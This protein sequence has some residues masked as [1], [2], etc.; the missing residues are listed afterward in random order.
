MKYISFL[1]LLTAVTFSGFS[2]SKDAVLGKWVNSSGEANIEIF[3]K[4][5]QYFGKI[6][7]LKNPKDDKGN[8]KTDLKNPEEKLKTR[9]ILGLQILNNFVYDGSKWT[10]GKIYDPKSGKTYSCNMTFNDAGD[11]NIRG[12]V[13]VA[14]LGR[15]DIWKRVK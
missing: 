1:L 8:V 9:P 4:G 5:D 3:K 11:L 6:V 10:D 13:G 12:Y 2:Q 15:T 14:L 7:W